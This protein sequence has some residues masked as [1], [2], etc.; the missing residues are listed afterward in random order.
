[1]A[2]ESNV[3]YAGV[4][5]LAKAVTPAA[6]CVCENGGAGAVVIKLPSRYK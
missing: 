6:T 1:M 3:E 5:E 4:K 2:E